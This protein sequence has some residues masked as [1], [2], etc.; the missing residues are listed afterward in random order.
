MT[1]R[2][3]PVTTR[4]RRSH[5]D[6][7]ERTQFWVTL[8]FLA[9][10][11]L[12][13]LV[14]GGAVA[15][16][17][18]NDH[19][20]VVARVNGTEINRDQWRQAQQIEAFRLQEGESRIRESLAAGTID[21][22][23]AQSRMD[24]LN[25]RSQ[26][27]ETRSIEDLI[28]LDLQAGLARSEGLSASAADVD[29]ALDKESS[30]P[31]LR[32][33]LAIFVTPETDPATGQSTAEQETA[34]KEKADQALAKLKAGDDF[35]AVAREYSTDASRDRGGEY[36]FLDK[37]NPTDPAWVEE[38]FALD[39]GGTTEVIEG[40]DGS[41]RIGRVAEIKPPVKDTTY[42]SRIPTEVGLDTY[43]KRLELEVLADHLK[44]KIGD[45]ATAG[46]VEQVFAYEIYAQGG[47]DPS[48]GQDAGAEVKASHILYSPKDD[49]DGAQSLAADDPAW[50][51]AKQLADKA[52]T[53]LRAVTDVTK[54]EEQFAAL[55]KAESDDTGSGARGGDLGFF[56]RATMVQEFGDAVFDKEH[57][58]GEIIGP[59]KTQFGWH[60]LM[61]ER[62]RA[63]PKDR[64]Q[65][66]HDKLEK[67]GANFQ[68][69]AR[70]ESDADNA[71]SG[72]EIGWVARH[73]LDDLVEEVLFKL[74][75]NKVS[76]VVTSDDGLRVYMITKKEKRPI[77]PA[78]KAI[79]AERAFEA[80]YT[81][82]KDAAD[83]F[84]DEELLGGGSPI[85]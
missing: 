53:E 63:A 21:Q 36:G 69:I 84:R 29:V 81:E 18:Y 33:V 83:I 26:E 78:R 47:A 20:K 17:Y 73:E 74:E 24:E 71:A 10:I 23:T 13:I 5:L 16:G 41:Y 79:V 45:A 40:A 42:A 52:A 57:E 46:D 61:F 4:K 67:P 3:K 34:A 85:E 54:R 49:P 22:A 55:A 48:T 28:D 44:T 6:S 2:A 25:Q 39:E 35:A 76:D 37:D 38:L 31:E 77:E 11:G 80:Y 59:V 9:I 62:S 60:V 1:F 82:K 43:K 72:G 56:N 8:G 64:I 30:T 58:K 7:E 75:P 50:E 65:A 14:L 32:K 12:A 70:Q 66:I 68:D 27:L 51:E 15:A 19:F